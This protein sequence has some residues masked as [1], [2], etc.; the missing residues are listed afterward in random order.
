MSRKFSISL[1]NDDIRKTMMKEV[2][3]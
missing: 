3:K 1:H 2:K